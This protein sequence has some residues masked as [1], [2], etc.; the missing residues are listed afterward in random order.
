MKKKKKI[1]KKNM[2]IGSNRN[3]D[4]LNTESMKKPNINIVIATK[5]DNPNAFF[6][7]AS[8]LI[9]MFAICNSAFRWGNNVFNW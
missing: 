8:G 2:N 5:K 6:I 3:K 4:A 1:A 7:N 9:I